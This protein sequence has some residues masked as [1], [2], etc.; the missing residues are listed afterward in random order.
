[1]FHKE[2]LSKITNTSFSSKGVELVHDIATIINSTQFGM[3]QI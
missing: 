2:F 3:K 1:M